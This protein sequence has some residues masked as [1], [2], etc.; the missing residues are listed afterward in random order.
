L[1]HVSNRN[2]D[3]VPVAAALVRAAAIAGRVQ[4]CV[5]SSA[6]AAD[7]MLA[8]LW[9]AAARRERDLAPLDGDPRWQ[10]LPASPGTAPWRDDFSNLA[11]VIR[12]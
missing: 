3:L 7:G 10:A 5:P 9:V 6:E 4:R 1:L 11:G 8:S 12:W 2:L